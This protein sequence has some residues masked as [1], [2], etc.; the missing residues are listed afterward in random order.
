MKYRIKIILLV[1]FISFRGIA[2]EYDENGKEIHGTYNGK[3]FNIGLNL[4]CYFANK[5]TASNYNGYGFDADGVRNTY[6]NSLMY[7]KIILQ[8]GGGYP[9]G[10]DQ[11]A[12]ALGVNPGEWNFIEDYMPNNMKYAPGFLLG[13]DMRYSM[14]NKNVILFNI[15]AA[16]LN[17]TG[18]FTIWAKPSSG[19]S[20]INNQY[21]TCDIKGVEQ[22]LMLQLGYQ[23]VFISE[24][25]IN[26]IL[27]GGINVTMAK[28]NKNEILIGDLLID[29]TESYYQPGVNNASLVQKQVGVG[30]GA[31]AGAGLNFN[32]NENFR[33][34]ILYNPS[35]EG[36]K[37]G[38]NTRLKLQHSAG[39]RIYYGL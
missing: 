28:M 13:L 12:P 11:I 32:M 35:Y 24:K 19:S 29:L 20:Q 27:E 34:Q 8:Y 31:F 3:G 37:L 1:L 6:E 36:I 10:V 7:N 23:H 33:F 18:N 14:D 39:L 26:P 9:G 17:I 21:R 16:Q 5:Y 38:T 2:Q 15:H 22:R 25:N 30:F 4:G